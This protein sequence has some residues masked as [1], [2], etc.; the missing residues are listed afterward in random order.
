MLTFS[1][2]IRNQKIDILVDR[3]WLSVH[4]QNNYL[5][6]GTL[7]YQY[8]TSVKFCQMNPLKIKKNQLKKQL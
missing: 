5:I 8:I 1:E 2:R 4:I 6:I 7:S 3:Y